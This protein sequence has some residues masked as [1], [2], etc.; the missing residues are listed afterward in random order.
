[1][2]DVPLLEEMA[3]SVNEQDVEAHRSRKRSRLF[4][5][6][7]AVGLVCVLLLLSLIHI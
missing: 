5:G 3:M 1:M 4:R 7:V 2:T 6:A